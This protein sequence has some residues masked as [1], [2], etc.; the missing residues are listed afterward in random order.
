MFSVTLTLLSDAN[1]RLL[2]D[3]SLE[4]RTYPSGQAGGVDDGDT[5]PTA[6]PY[7]VLQGQ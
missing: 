2:M 6:G 1:E 4:D 7:T 5:V 3:C